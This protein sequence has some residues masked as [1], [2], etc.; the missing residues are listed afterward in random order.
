MRKSIYQ[1]AKQ[2]YA[3]YGIDVEKAIKKLGKVKI[4]FFSSG[5]I[6]AEVPNISAKYTAN[7]TSNIT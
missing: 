6:S 5:I 1:D 2:K 3:K 7:I 4:S